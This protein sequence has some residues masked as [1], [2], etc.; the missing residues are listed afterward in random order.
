MCLTNVLPIPGGFT[1]QFLGWKVFISSGRF[2]NSNQELSAVYC[3][4][5][6]VLPTEKWLHSSSYLDKDYAP[7]LQRDGLVQLESEDGEYY[8]AGWH[9]FL[10]EQAA[11]HW[12]ATQELSDTKVVHIVCRKVVAFGK[13]WFCGSYKEHPLPKPDAD[14]AVVKEIFIPDTKVENLNAKS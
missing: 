2:P 12:A 4:S 1:G 13:Q 11:H 14:V 9:V 8:E 5:L 7:Y 10:S 3:G 6:E